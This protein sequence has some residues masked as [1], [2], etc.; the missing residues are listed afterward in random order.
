MIQSAIETSKHIDAKWLCKLWN[1]YCSSANEI[2]LM[3]HGFHQLDTS[4]DFEMREE[5]RFLIGVLETK[6]KQE[7]AQ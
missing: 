4:R 7:R 6:A 2:E 1:C 5:V 3:L